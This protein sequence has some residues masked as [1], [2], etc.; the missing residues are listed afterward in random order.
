MSDWCYLLSEKF[1]GKKKEKPASKK[2]APKEGVAS[3]TAY[4]R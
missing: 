1:P 4:L 3:Q 2:K